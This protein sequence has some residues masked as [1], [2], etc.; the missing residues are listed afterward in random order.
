[1]ILRSVDEDANVKCP[2]ELLAYDMIFY[3]LA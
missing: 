3:Y 2:R 1:M